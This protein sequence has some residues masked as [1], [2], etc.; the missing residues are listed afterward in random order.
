MPR[1][2]DSI[3]NQELSISTGCT[4]VS[5]A[6]IS[7]KGR[8][9][10]H[11][12]QWK[13]RKKYER[14][15]EFV[16]HYPALDVPFHWQEPREVEV[17]PHSDLFHELMPD[18]VILRLFDNMS[19]TQ[20]H[21]YRICTKR[22]ERMA[23]IV[24]KVNLT[25]NIWLGTSVESRDQLSRI[26]HLRKCHPKIRYVEFEPL[27]EDLGELDLTGIQW[28]TVSGGVDPSYAEMK[29]QWVKD[30]Q[31]QCKEQNVPFYFR[32]WGSNTKNN[33]DWTDPTRRSTHALYTPGGCLLDG[34]I[35][36][37]LPDAP[38]PVLPRKPIV[39]KLF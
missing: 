16:I 22:P 32:R 9:H 26:D 29:Y 27:M 39:H 23:D 15:F 38:P 17:N 2:S 11:E 14:G 31:R 36:R 30:I 7:C 13:K 24:I 6:C 20:M 25:G 18:N 37:E 10:S 5:P 8:K 28:V 19:R 12:E 21:R 33:P 35:V 4:S 3:N 34:K 1:Q